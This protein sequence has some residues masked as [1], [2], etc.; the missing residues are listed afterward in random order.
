MAAIKERA[1]T[2]EDD[3]RVA[4]EECRQTNKHTHDLE[5]QLKD[6]AGETTNQVPFCSSLCIHLVCLWFHMD[7]C[8]CN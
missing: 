2:S 7:I 8:L 1:N 4:R 3:A 5:R 6:L